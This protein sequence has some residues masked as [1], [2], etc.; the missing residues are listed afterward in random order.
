MICPMRDKESLSEDLAD[1][2]TK[3]RGNR[4]TLFMTDTICHI[5]SSQKQIALLER[6]NGE[7]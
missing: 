3:S 6:R 2:S 5:T 4:E 7:E 1:G